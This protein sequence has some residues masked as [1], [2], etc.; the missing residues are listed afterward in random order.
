MGAIL[1]P[2]D[3]GGGGGAEI[4]NPLRTPAEYHADPC[5]DT[6]T[7]ANQLANGT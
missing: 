2:L 1:W 5:S 7:L 3:A 4:T 6:R